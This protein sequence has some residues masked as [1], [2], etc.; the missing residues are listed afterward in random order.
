MKE[1]INVSSVIGTLSLNYEYENEYSC[2]FEPMKF[3][4]PSAPFMLVLDR[5]GVTFLR[6]FL[7]F[8]FPMQIVISLRVK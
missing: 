3:P 1:R 8:S 6:C 5:E 2:D 7:L 4:Q